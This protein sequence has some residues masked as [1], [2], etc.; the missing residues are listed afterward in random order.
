MGLWTAGGA[1]SDRVSV[2]DARSGARLPNIDVD[3][4]GSPYLVG[5]VTVK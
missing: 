3:G 1:H 4:P 2:L 5:V